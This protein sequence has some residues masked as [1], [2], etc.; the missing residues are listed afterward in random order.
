M[1]ASIFGG[2]IPFHRRGEK[3][4][5]SGYAILSFKVL[6]DLTVLY[7]SFLSIL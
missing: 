6:H 2:A 5:T 1:K 7:F 4:D 3:E